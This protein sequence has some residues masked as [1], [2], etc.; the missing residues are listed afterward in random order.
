MGYSEGYLDYAGGMKVRYRLS[1][2][3][4]RAQ[5]VLLHDAG[6]R[7]DFYNNLFPFY[8]KFKIALHAVELRGH[9]LSSGAY[10]HIDDF[11]HYVRD[12]K[13]FLFGHLRNEPV[14]L[15]GQGAGAL[16][17]LRTAQDS[18][19]RVRGMVLSSPLLALNRPLPWRIGVFFLS[20]FHSEFLLPFRE[21]DFRCL[22]HDEKIVRD[23]LEEAKRTA[24]G[25]TAGFYESAFREKRRF[26]AGWRG[27]VNIPVFLLFGDD[28]RIIDTERTK[29]MFRSIYGDSWHLETKTYANSYHSLLLETERAKISDD[30]LKW[31][32]FN[33]VK[34]NGGE[35][36]KG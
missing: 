1:D 34:I 17:A 2:A 25:L 35:I 21:E 5:A 3:Q 31:I 23:L 6:E 10:R 18:R 22:S 12:V 15:I 26:L 27:L 33:E 30:I 32:L 14:Y 29:V 9:G 28:D 8:E 11:S 20:R 13:R 36:I 7:L 4:G 16:V 24:M 19:F